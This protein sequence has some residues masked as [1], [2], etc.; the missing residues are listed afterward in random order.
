[1]ELEWIEGEREGKCTS[2]TRRFS[3]LVSRDVS[4]GSRIEGKGK[5]PGKP[6]SAFRSQRRCC[7]T[8]TGSVFEEEGAAV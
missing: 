6:P 7:W 8:S 1:M 3:S 4:C 2:R 5:V